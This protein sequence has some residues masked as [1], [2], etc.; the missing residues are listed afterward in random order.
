MWCL[1][2]YLPLLIGDF[3][4]E[5]DSH[6]ANMIT[7]CHIV[8]YV[9]SPKCTAETI[10]DLEHLIKLFLSQFILLYPDESVTPKMHYIIH[11]PTCMRKLASIYLLT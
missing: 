9:L 4:P 11:Y 8:D 7:F 1:I 6:W 5:G 3:I 10:D 2:R